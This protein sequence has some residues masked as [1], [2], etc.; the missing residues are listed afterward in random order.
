MGRVHTGC[1]ETIVTATA[2]A[3]N[4]SVINPGHTV[5][6]DG[7]MAVFTLS[8]VKYMRCGLA[9]SNAVVMTGCACILNADMVKFC[10]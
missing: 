1:D 10:A 9:Y 6:S 2:Y 5:K 4:G 3:Y 8:C 7:V